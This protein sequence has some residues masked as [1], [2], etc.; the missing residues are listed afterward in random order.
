[1][2]YRY[3]EFG[4]C[5]F[6]VLKWIIELYLSI[7]DYTRSAAQEVNLPVLDWPAPLWYSVKTH[8]SIEQ[9]IFSLRMVFML[10]T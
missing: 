1:M 8:C 7:L 4:N 2:Q 3:A 5:K 6:E 10:K 9:S